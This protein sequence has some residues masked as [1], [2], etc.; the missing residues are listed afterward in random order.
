MPKYEIKLN[1][2]GP[3]FTKTGVVD[4]AFRAPSFTADQM[5]A[6][7]EYDIEI[8]KG[9]VGELRDVYDEPAPPLTQKYARRKASKG[10]PPERNL[11]YTGIM[12]KGLD[13]L[14]SDETHV[15]VGLKGSPQFRKALF[16]QNID[17]WFG[18]SGHDEEK[19]MEEKIRP[20]F[21]QNIDDLLK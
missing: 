15:K 6:I 7:G 8:M 14:E 10:L 4:R 11:S 17:P 5:R 2:T 18:L 20:L 16:N 21:Q 3:L 13:I 12:L 19:L 1:T 9:R